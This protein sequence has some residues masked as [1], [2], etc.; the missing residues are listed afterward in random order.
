MC[1]IPQCP[2]PPRRQTA[3]TTKPSVVSPSLV[4]AAVMFAFVFETFFILA[5]GVST[6]FSLLD[7]YGPHHYLKPV[8]Y[9]TSCAVRLLVRD[10]THSLRLL[11][12]RCLAQF[13]SRI[14]THI[15]NFKH[16]TLFSL[17]CPMRLQNMISTDDSSRHG[18]VK[19][20]LYA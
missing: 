3:T 4:F 14:Q 5:P 7:I 1:L 2:P 9:S 16:M 20:C 13:Y 18:C 10:V 8:R 12:L 11:L 15:H 19:H 6:S 17:T